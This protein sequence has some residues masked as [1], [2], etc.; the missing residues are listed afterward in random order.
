MIA[1]RSISLFVV[2]ALAEISGAYLIWQWI[3]AGKPAFWGL[4]GLIA[5]SVYAVTQTFQEFNFGRTFAAYGG[6][7]IATALLWGWLVDHRTPDRWDFLGVCICLLGAA[8]ILWGP[9][10]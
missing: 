5:L 2:A 4:V 1:I 8:I 7:F 3:R 9:R 10:R 6:I